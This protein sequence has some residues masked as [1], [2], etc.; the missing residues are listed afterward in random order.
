MQIKELEAETV[1]DWNRFLERSPQATFFHLAQWKDIIQL[2]F[3]HRCYFLYALEQ[4]EITGILPLVHVKSRLFGNALVSTPFCVQGGVVSRNQKSHEA[5][6][7]WSIN[8]AKNLKV[9]YL[10]LRYANAT[11]PGWP[12]KNDLYVNFRKTLLTTV[13]ENLNA[14]PRKQRAMVRKGMQAGL[15]SCEETDVAR[16]YH[17]YS[18]SVR[19]LGTPVFSQRYFEI[20][21]DKFSNQCRMLSIQKDGKVISAVL[22]FYFRDEVL[23]YYGGGSDS[24]REWKANDFMYWELMRRSCEQGLK[25]FDYGRSKVGTGSY[26]FKKNWGFEPHALHYEYQLI[27]ANAIPNINPLN[28]KYRLFINLWKKMPLYLTQ[29]IGP[30]IVKNLG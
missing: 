8:L 16:F 6:Q 2:A 25:V 3:G 29:L 27:S 1:A 11:N 21:M 30:H 7:H 10:E 19:N 20:L 28:P 26:N 17:M 18:L 15:T 14:I 23:P 24:A 4:E 13:D 22:S 9:D 12:V 5:L